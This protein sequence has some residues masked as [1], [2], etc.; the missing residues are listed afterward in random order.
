M[1]VPVRRCGKVSRDENAFDPLGQSAQFVLHSLRPTA[2]ATKRTCAA[3]G[4]PRSSRSNNSGTAAA[5]PDGRGEH[6]ASCLADLRRAKV[7]DWWRSLDPVTRGILL[8]EQ[9]DAL[10]KAGIVDPAHQWGRAG[11]GAGGFGT[12]EPTAHDAFLL[13]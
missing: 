12:E 11:P 5:P 2:T 13:S 8:D 4:S 9:G 7:A 1:G 6:P 10:K 3:A